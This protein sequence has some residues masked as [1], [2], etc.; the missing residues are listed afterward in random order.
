MYKSKVWREVGSYCVVVVGAQVESTEGYVDLCS[1]CSLPHPPSDA[2]V[3][4]GSRISQ[5]TVVIRRLEHS[6]GRIL[7]L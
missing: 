4:G 3:V 5:Q 1:Y 7:A 6:I 2:A